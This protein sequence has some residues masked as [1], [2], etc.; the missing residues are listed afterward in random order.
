VNKKKKPDHSKQDPGDPVSRLR[1][2]VRFEYLIN[3]YVH[4]LR[5]PRLPISCRTPDNHQPRHPYIRSSGTCRAGVPLH[6]P[7]A[8]PLAT[9]LSMNSFVSE[10]VITR[11]SD[12]R[13]MATYKNRCCIS[14]SAGVRGLKRSAHI[15]NTTR[16]CNPFEEATVCTFTDCS[17]TSVRE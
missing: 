9:I 8:S 11:T 15:T 12:A 16:Y 13:V 7:T 1:A 4:G 6:F 17:K 5:G 2:S 14:E 3:Y 10:Y